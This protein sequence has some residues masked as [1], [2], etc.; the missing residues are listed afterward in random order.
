MRT[1][2][3]SQFPQSGFS[4]GRPGWYV[5][6]WWLVEATLFRHS[7]HNAYGFR[8]ALLRLFGAKIGP[9]VKIRPD[10]QFYFPWRVEIGA[11]S[12]I[13]NKA[14]L[15]SLA[16]I[17]IGP[18]CVVSQEAYLNTGSHDITRPHFDLITRPIVIEAGAWVGARAFVNLGV[19]IHENAVI[20]AMSN[21]TKDLPANMICVGNPCKPIKERGLLRD[22]ELPVLVG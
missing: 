17:T 5:L 22:S 10:A 3:L 2:D 18:N 9:G 4:R 11:H 16:Q 12:W 19:T 15:Y 14:M 20:G 8:N 6:L 21:V 7:L 1:M 13:G